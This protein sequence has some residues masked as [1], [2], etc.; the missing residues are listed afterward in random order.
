MSKHGAIY[1]N[2]KEIIGYSEEQRKCSNC[3]FFQ[4]DK[5]TVEY[6]MQLCIRNPDI[7]LPIKASACCLKWT[8]P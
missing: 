3:T 1:A 5:P 6:P 2:L 4:A 7:V 8:K